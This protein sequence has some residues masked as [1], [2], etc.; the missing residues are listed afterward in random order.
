MKALDLKKTLYEITEQYPELI[1]VL[2]D[3]GFAGVANPAMRTT[4]GRIMTIPKGCEQL[5]LRLEEVI[6]TLREKGFE[7]LR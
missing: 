2:K 4:H 5:G 7:A 1:P 6:K 3:L